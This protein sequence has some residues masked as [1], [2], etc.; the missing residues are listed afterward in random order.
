MPRPLPLFGDRF[1]EGWRSL[2][3]FALRVEANHE[4]MKTPRAGLK[5]SGVEMSY[6]L[7]FLK[8][9]LLWENFQQ[10]VFIR[11]LMGFESN[12]G[13]ETLRPGIAKPR[14]LEESENAILDGRRYR[15][16]HD[17]VQVMRRSDQYFDPAASHFRAIIGANQATLENFAALRH[18]IA[19]AQSHARTEFDAATMRMAGRR[20]YGQAGR[21]LRTERVAG[22]RW[23]EAICR[24]MSDIAHQIC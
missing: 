9:F 19:H 7:L 13:V 16:W 8:V 6:E 24:E 10:D 22:Q 20:F 2:L 14:T 21:F 1:D 17:P 12:G 4:A 15:L 18:Q 11:L 3:S 5:N 23:F